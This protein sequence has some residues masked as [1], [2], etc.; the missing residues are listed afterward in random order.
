MQILSEIHIGWGISADKPRMVQICRCRRFSAELVLLLMFQRGCYFPSGPDGH[1]APPYAI[2]RLGPRVAASNCVRRHGGYRLRA[3]VDAKTAV[4]D[5]S[6]KSFPRYCY[7]GP[8]LGLWVG[9]E[10][11]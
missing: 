10:L 3:G 2:S 8:G 4:E 11:R 6:A 1:L 5:L 9:L 7:I